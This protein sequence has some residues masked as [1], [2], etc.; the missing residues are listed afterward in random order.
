MHGINVRDVEWFAA[1]K[2][3][4]EEAML[5]YGE[6]LYNEKLAEKERPI[7]LADIEASEERVAEAY[8]VT[9]EELEA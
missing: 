6:A 1:L 5:A 4:Q 8:G 9:T 3:A 7:V 2:G